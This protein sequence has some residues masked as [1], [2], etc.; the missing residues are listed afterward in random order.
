M[1]KVQFTLFGGKITAA[2]AE[3]GPFGFLGIATEEIKTKNG[4]Q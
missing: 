4:M 3:V 2:A 1:G